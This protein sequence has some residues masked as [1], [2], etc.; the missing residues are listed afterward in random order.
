MLMRSMSRGAFDRKFRTDAD[1]E[2]WFVR[3]RWGGA[4]RCAHCESTN[5]AEIASRRPMP[6][7]CRDCRKHFSVTTNTPMHAT[8]LGARTWLLA[9]YLIL[10]HPKGISSIQLAADLGITQKSAWHLG[11]R[12]REALAAEGV[13]DF[14]G[15]VEV[16][17][18][19]IGGKAKNMHARQRR[20]RI[21]G[22]GSVDKTPVVG[23]L[24]RATAQVHMEVTSRTDGP[25]LRGIVTAHTAAGATIYTDDAS[26]YR[27]LPNHH[28]VRHTAG[29]YVRG[30]VQHQRDRE[31]V[32]A[33]EAAAT[34][35]CTTT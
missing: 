22:R 12:I 35:A 8:K 3:H 26:A 2:A 14:A 19:Y 23:V 4:V 1:A 20:E 27:T 28:S 30:D 9:M 33:A 21:T 10:S 32:G 7:R 34:S 29:E 31:P 25:A 24:D 17:E 11:H 15:P 16:D 13:G 5:V 18:A 6:Y